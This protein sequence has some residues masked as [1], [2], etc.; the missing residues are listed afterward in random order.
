MRAEGA[1][2]GMLTTLGLVGAKASVQNPDTVKEGPLEETREAAARGQALWEAWIQVPVF[3]RFNHL[4]STF[5]VSK[6][7]IIQAAQ[8]LP[9]REGGRR[10]AEAAG[11]PG[12]D[13]QFHRSLALWI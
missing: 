9:P 11:P 6:F 3:P 13:S 12:L 5:Y 8:T 10:M 4:L 1:A 2:R 7:L